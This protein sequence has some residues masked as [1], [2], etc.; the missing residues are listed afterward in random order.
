MKKYAGKTIDEILDKISKEKNVDKEKIKY[1][2]IEEK[3]G[4]LGI[5]KE[6]TI[7][8]YVDDDILEFIESYLNNYFN[9]IKING[10][11]NS[12]IENKVFNI[13][14]ELEDNYNALLIG[15]NGKNLVSLTNV[16]KK[17]VETNFDKR[18][19]L[20]IDINNYKKEKY[21]KLKRMSMHY[22]K[23]LQNTKGSI[24]LDPMPADERKII[25]KYLSEFDHI[26]TKSE[27][28]GKNRRLRISYE[29]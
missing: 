23:E 27:G 29:K 9:N 4:F 20:L 8:A 14:I 16:V 19:M 12:Y 22:A 1:N 7:S 11:I 3:N 17:A 24:L 5:G 26:S 18:I 10:E 2:V 21:E 28:E 13:N 6:V 15:K 25:H